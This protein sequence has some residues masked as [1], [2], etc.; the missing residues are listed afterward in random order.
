MS[1]VG[2]GAVG[3]KSGRLVVCDISR[4]PAVILNLENIKEHLVSIQGNCYPTSIE[5]TIQEYGNEGY[6]SILLLVGT[7]CGGNLVMFKIVPMGNG[8]F[9][10]IF[11]DKTAHL[12]YRTTDAGDSEGSFI[13]QLIPINATNG[14]SAIADMSTFN[15]LSQ[16]ILL[17]G[18]VIATSSRDVRV[19]KLPKQKLSH[20]VIDD[21][22]LKVSV[23]NYRD[24]GVVLAIL[25]KL[26]LS[27]FAR[28]H[29]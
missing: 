24:H 23:V 12:N 28:Y 2:F 22:C 4:G 17:P 21:T 13:S 8:G 3:Y 7:N 18:Y 15:K 20:K 5:F 19:L 6:S 14:A 10:V 29:H 9:E 1:E 27:S 25:V 16:G 26:G 11:A